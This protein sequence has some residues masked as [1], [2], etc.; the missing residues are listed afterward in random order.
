MYHSINAQQLFRNYINIRAQFKI[1]E[2]LDEAPSPGPNNTKK[3]MVVI[4][5]N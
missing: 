5:S 4:N 2:N 3:K 1:V